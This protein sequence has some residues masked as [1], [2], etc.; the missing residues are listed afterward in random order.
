MNLEKPHSRMFVSASDFFFRPRRNP[1]SESMLGIF[2]CTAPHGIRKQ[3]TERH[4]H[5]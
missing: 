4:M 2:R 5:G 1:I 3:K